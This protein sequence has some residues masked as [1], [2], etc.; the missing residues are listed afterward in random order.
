MDRSNGEVTNVDT[1]LIDALWLGTLHRICTRAAHDVKG[2]LNGVAVNLEVVRSRSEKP[3]APASAVRQYATVAANQLEVVIA[4]SDALLALSRPAREPVEIGPV[5]RWIGALLTPAARADG[6]RLELAGS[7]D[8]LGVTSAGGSA[9]RAAIGGS[10]LAA[11]QT[12]EHVSCVADAGNGSQPPTI[13][14]EAPDGTPIA[15]D[16][17]LIATVA[18]AGIHIRAESGAILISFPR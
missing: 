14:V 16:G 9:V 2:A 6:A 11:L 7:F 12:C 15:A 5:V 3:D 13:R 10:L 17:E 4:M 18:H 8:V 1:R